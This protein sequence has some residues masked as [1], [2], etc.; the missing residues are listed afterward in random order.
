M[1]TQCLNLRTRPQ[2]VQFWYI[3]AMNCNLKEVY[4]LVK[5]MKDLTKRKAYLFFVHFF[6]V[7]CPVCFIHLID[8][9]SKKEENTSMLLSGEKEA[10]KKV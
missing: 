7:L 6:L 2:I 1:H 8:V 4:Y 5:A 3:L 10:N 9:T